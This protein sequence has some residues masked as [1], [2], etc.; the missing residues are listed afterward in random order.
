M[1]D[2]VFDA[3][4]RGIERRGLLRTALLAAG[5]GGFVSLAPAGIA[6]QPDGFCTEK[7]KGARCRGNGQC[8][9]GRCKKKKRKR[10][11]K[12][13]CSQLQAHCSSTNDCCLPATPNEIAIQ[14]GLRGMATQRTC[15]M[16]NGGHCNESADCCGTLQCRAPGETLLCLPPP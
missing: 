16:G 8:C 10:K 15:C 7:P 1:D 2:R 5:L 11:G 4:A 6:A 13:R 12:C 9:S 3:L 14:C